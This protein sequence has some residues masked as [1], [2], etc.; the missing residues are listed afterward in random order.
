MP[1]EQLFA[2]AEAALRGGVRVLQYRNKTAAAAVQKTEAARLRELCYQ[3]N[4]LFII[5]DDVAL[6]Q[7]IGADGV[8]LGQS[9][10]PLA[11]VRRRVGEAM[12]IGIS[13]HASLPSALQAQADGASYVAFGRLFASHTKPEA[14]PAELTVLAQAKSQLAIPVVAI[15]G[16]TRDNAPRVIAESADMIA[17]IH[18]LFAPDDL[19]EIENRART[20]TQLFSNQQ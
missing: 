15:G 19:A 12:L 18:D 20:F 9:D 8:H 16:I 2:K 10:A 5:N 1:G 7:A 3:H 13:C 6:A 4:S 14:P 17:V 11:E